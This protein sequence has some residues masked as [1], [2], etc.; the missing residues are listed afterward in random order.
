MFLLK[1]INLYLYF[2]FKSAIEKLPKIKYHKN[3]IAEN[4]CVICQTE[5]EEEEEITKLPC[6]NADHVFHTECVT[7]WLK[8]NGICP[9]CRN[10]I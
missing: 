9:I 2:F 6:P 7:R 4:T 5:F 8:I 1:S 10:K 3:D